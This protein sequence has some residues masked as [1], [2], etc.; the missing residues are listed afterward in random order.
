MGPLLVPRFGAKKMSPHSG[1]TY[2]RPRFRVCFWFPK[3]GRKL[4]PGGGIHLPR[5]TA[6]AGC[7][8]RCR[9]MPEE[10]GVYVKPVSRRG[11]FTL[12]AAQEQERIL[13]LR[14]DWCASRRALEQMHHRFAK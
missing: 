5:S 14:I 9:R 6:S 12:A 8:I 2:S 3:W 4:D 13:C 7:V 10:V 1:E 11:H